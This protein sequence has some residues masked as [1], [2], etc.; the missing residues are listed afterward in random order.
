MCCRLALPCSTD[1]KLALKLPVGDAFC[2][3]VLCAAGGRRLHSGS[4][5][6]SLATVLQLGRGALPGAAGRH[7]ALMSHM[8]LAV[9]VDDRVEVGELLLVI[10]NLCVVVLS[11]RLRREV[12]P[13]GEVSMIAASF[14]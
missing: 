2:C 1:H 3:A 6:K 13:E 8:P 5:H 12:L 10:T 11:I 14:H 9:I 4:K 7:A